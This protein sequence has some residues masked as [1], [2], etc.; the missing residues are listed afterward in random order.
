MWV[1]WVVNNFDLIWM[2]WFMHFGKEAMF[3]K[4]GVSCLFGD[5]IGGFRLRADDGTMFEHGARG[6]I[7][8][9]GSIVK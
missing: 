3:G 9:V 1:V 5:E 7:S 8:V 4:A 2:A 6:K